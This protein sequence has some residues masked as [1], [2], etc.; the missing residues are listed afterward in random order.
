MPLSPNTSAP[1]SWIDHDLHMHSFLSR[2]CKTPWISFP[3]NMIARAA[4]AGM[5]T[6][7]FSDHMWDSAVPGATAWYA[8]QNFIY[9]S[10][11]RRLL[12]PDTR[13]VRI[14]FGCETEMRGDG[15]PCITPEVAAQFDFVL[16]P[17][18]HLHIKGILPPSCRTPQQIAD[19]MV[20]RFLRSLELDYVTGIPHSF[21]PGNDQSLADQVV[22][23]IS[24]RQ[25]HDCF[26]RAAERRIGIEVTTNF[27]PSLK[28]PDQRQYHDETYLRILTVAR[29]V[30]C[31]F[32]LGSDAHNVDRVG[33]T[34]RLA[35]FL[36]QLDI[37]PA[38]LHSLVSRDGK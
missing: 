24:D 34:R 13:G 17:H 15:A 19:F 29:Q 2:C 31:C 3:E 7:G 16:M 33:T 1:D 36:N 26:G 37:T 14:L 11:I 21:V 25:L 20:D 6:I 32:Y 38:H 35:P 4:A 22:A 12:P 5:K 9:I 23:C 28:P 8:P 30:G 18:S 27:F 10:Q